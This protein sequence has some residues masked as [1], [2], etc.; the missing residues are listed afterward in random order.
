MFQEEKT[1]NLRFSLEA[2]FPEDYDGDEDNQAWLQEWEKYI[3]P[4]ML[5]VLFESLRKHRT[6]SAHV[7]NRG[8]SPLDEIEIAMVRDISPDPLR[9]R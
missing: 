8:I 5:K 1:F 4:D 7:R 3:K 9:V 2:H 6:W